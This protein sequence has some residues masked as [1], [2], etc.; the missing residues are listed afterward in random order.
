MKNETSFQRF[1]TEYVAVPLG[2][3]IGICGGARVIGN[4]VYIY[5]NYC[6]EACSDA[7]FTGLGIIDLENR[8]QNIE[9]PKADLYDP[10]L[11]FR[12]E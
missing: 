3:Y 1:Q 10:F 8:T 5:A 4:G 6:G 12:V 9:F 2:F 11:Y 7:S